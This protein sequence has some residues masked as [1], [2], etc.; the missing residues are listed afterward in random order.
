MEDLWLPFHGYRQGDELVRYTP[1]L[2]RNRP[3]LLSRPDA[4]LEFLE[5]LPLQA[6]LEALLIP[7]LTTGKLP[8][9]G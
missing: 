9:A 8:P 5:K 7:A 1:V 2:E 6:A 3:D 4:H